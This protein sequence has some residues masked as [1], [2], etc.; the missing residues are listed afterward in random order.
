MLTSKQARP[1]RLPADHLMTRPPSGLRA[2]LPRREDLIRRPPVRGPLDPGIGAAEQERADPLL[3]DRFAT[4]LVPSRWCVAL[5]GVILLAGSPF[6]VRKGRC[7]VLDDWR[8]LDSR[9]RRRG[10]VERR[11]HADPGEQAKGGQ[12]HRREGAGEMGQAILFDDVER[13]AVEQPAEDAPQA[14]RRRRRRSRPGWRC[15][16]A[17][18][19][20]AAWPAVSAPPARQGASRLRERAAAFAARPFWGLRERDR[21]RPALPAQARVRTEFGAPK[22]GSS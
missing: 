2:K 11:P 3:L 9:H 14:P 18:R 7:R 4:A 5:I 10:E 19:P 22:E 17:R 6:Q 13:E 20:S 15:R 21:T 8:Q 1:S 12:G 16:R